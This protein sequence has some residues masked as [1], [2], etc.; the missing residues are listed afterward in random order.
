ME[1][2]AIG[3][4]NTSIGYRDGKKDI[5]VVGGISASLSRGELVALI[6]RNG[7][8]KSTLLRTLAGY[9]KPLSGTI[10]YDGSEASLLSLQELARKVSVVLTD[11]ASVAN[12][13]VVELVSLGRTPYTN[14]WGTLGNDDKEIVK[15][16][17]EMMGILPFAERN[18][19]MLSDGERQKCLISK[20]IAQQTSTILLDEPTA[21]LDFQSK[22]HL[23]QMLRRLAKEEDKA[24][25]VSTHDL[26]LAL[27]I[28]DR[29]WLVADGKVVAGTVEELSADGTLQAFIEDDCIGYNAKDNRI[30]IK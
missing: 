22:V 14:F 29:I 8:G 30:E 23:M 21:Y 9:Q 26:E 20:A 1:L 17:M 19:S 2:C 6:G 10:E 12:M 16:A 5:V 11:T 4:M 15:Q 18:I 7:A 13:S 3:L 25:L 27:R 28:A 24:V